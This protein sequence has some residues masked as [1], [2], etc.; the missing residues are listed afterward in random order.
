MTRC[1]S[2]TVRCFALG[3]ADSAALAAAA[4]A[5]TMTWRRGRSAAVKAE[6]RIATPTR[7]QP[8]HNLRIGKTPL[9]HSKS[10]PK[11]TALLRGRV[12]RSARLPGLRDPLRPQRA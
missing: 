2:R 4:A 3:V 9:S 12:G 1:G 7:A 5:P 6:L 8:Y 11:V 10:P